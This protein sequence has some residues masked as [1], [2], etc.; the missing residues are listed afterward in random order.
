[1]AAVL[2]RVPSEYSAEDVK[3]LRMFRNGI[4]AVV[5]KKHVLIVGDARFMERYGFDFSAGD[6]DP[7]SNGRATLCISFDGAMSAKMNVKYTIEPLFEVLVERLAE[8]EIFC[9][10]ETQDPLIHS[11]MAARLRRRGKTPISI[12]HK[13]ARDAHRNVRGRADA[14]KEPTGILARRSRLLLA[15][16]VIV[17]KRLRS[18]RRKVT[19]ATLIGGVFSLAAASLLLLLGLGEE[20]NQ[21][22]LLAC[23]ALLTV[24]SLIVGLCSLPRKDYIS[25]SSFDR[26]KNTKET[27]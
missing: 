8:N 13:T 9:A 26:E 6:P 20:V 21:Y 25:L 12:V 2:S 4:E 19:V 5:D 17:C 16:L 22:L 3:I 15:E 23:H 27:K 10:V 1:M 24:I 11:A 18:I 14:R 7:V